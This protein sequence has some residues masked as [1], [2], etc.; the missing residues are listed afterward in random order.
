M[1]TTPETQAY[2]EQTIGEA[3]NGNRSAALAMIDL[4]VGELN[5]N[6]LNI[7]PDIYEYF[8]SRLARL[9]EDDVSAD[10]ALHLKHERGAGRPT[11][12][13]TFEWK[14]TVAAFDILTRRQNPDRLAIDNDHIVMEFAQKHLHKSLNDKK[15]RDI[16]KLCEPMQA[17]DDRDIEFLSIPTGQ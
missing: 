5:K 10:E 13:R 3:L 11:D 1:A 8:I 15:L 9:T 2:I 6:I 16:R 4:L 12:P 14:K 17:M 7:Q